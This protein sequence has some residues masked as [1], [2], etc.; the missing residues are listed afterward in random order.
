MYTRALDRA[1]IRVVVAQ[2][3]VLWRGDVLFLYLVTVLE[4]RLESAEANDRRSRC[5]SVNPL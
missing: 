4:H 5:A 1:V 3:D 2:M